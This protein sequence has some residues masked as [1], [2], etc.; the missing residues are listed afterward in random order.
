MKYQKKIDKIIKT[1]DKSARARARFDEKI[2]L[3]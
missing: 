2:L 3:F 1:S